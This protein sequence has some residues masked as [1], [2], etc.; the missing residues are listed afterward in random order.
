MKP[1]KD[2]V[3]YYDRIVLFYL[4][5]GMLVMATLAI[6][7]GILV[8]F[9]ISIVIAIIYFVGLT[10]LIV[11]TKKLTNDLLKRVHFNLSLVLRNENDRIFTKFGIKARPGFLSKWIEFHWLNP[12]GLHIP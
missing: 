6:I 4:F 12:Y 2:K 3:A 11:R 1:F 7:L 5:I 9:G 10:F 8:N